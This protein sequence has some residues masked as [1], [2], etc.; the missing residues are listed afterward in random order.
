[1]KNSEIIKTN[2]LEANHIETIKDT[3]RNIVRRKVI[4]HFK[5][6]A[7]LILVAGTALFF[8]SCT[9][10]G[11]VTSEPA[12]YEHPRPQRP[13]EVH[14]WIDGDWDYNR[15]SHV[16]VQRN[17]YWEQPRPNHNYVSGQWQT[18]PKGKYWSKGHW[19]KN[20]HQNHGQQKKHNSR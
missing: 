13:S 14:V 2:V 7:I 10:A 18:S 4:C 16:Y 12:Y 6:L 15:S 5:K 9:T 3:S 19:Q 1:M 17:G 11:Y 8:N 20:G